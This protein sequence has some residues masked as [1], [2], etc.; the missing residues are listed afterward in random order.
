MNDHIIYSVQQRQDYE[1]MYK[2]K[3]ALQKYYEF[4]K[5]TTNGKILWHSERLKLFFDITILVEM[6]HDND[7]FYF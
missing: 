6:V 2:N 7:S 5:Q 4:S 3:K 1:A